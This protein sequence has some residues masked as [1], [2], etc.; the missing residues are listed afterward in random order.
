MPPQVPEL[1]RIARALVARGF[2][3]IPLENGTKR[4]AT[5]WARYQHET[6]TDRD[7]I[8]WFA[9]GQRTGYGITTGPHS[10]I[11]VIDVDGDDGWR[12][13]ATHLPSTPMRVRT[14]KGEHWYYRHPGVLVRNAARLRTE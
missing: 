13:A 3:V 14:R 1:L 10:G 6:P 4:P 2:S 12:W 7:L 5:P 11:V 8:A 9:S